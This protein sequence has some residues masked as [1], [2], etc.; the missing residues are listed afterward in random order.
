MKI[1]VYKIWKQFSSWEQV[2][3]IEPGRQVTGA[4]AVSL[5]IVK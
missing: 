2:L 3:Q 5:D 4:E 1:G